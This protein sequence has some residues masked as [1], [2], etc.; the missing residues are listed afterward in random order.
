MLQKLKLSE[1]TL[2]SGDVVLFKR[3][4]SKAWQARIKRYSGHWLDISTAENDFDKAKKAAEKQFNYMRYLQEE[5][6][7]DVTKK[8][9]SVAQQTIREDYNLNYAAKRAFHIS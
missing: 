7:V 4:N 9:E 3:K 1:R 5:G 6:K 8:F 2:C